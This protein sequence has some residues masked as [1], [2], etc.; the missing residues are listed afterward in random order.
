MSLIVAPPLS[1]KE[2]ARRTVVETIDD[3]CMGMAAQLSYYLCLSL[4]PALLFLIAVSSFFSLDLLTDEVG[5]A[6]G[7]VVSP[8]ILSLIQGQMQRLANGAD[9]GILTLGCIGAL[10]GSSSALVAVVSTVNRAYDLQETRPWWRVRLLALA[11]TVSLA[12]LILIAAAILL[13]GPRLAA[14]LGL[15][16]DSVL[17]GWT[18]ALVRWPMAFALVAFAIGLVYNYAPDADQDWLWVTPGAVVA[19][20]LWLLSSLVFKFYVETF[21]DYEATYGAIGAMLVLL[22]WLYISALGI[23][24]GAELNSEIELAAPYSQAKLTTADGRRVIG[25]RAARLFDQRPPSQATKAPPATGAR[26][27]PDPVP[28][29]LFT[30]LV[31]AL[32]APRRLS[33]DA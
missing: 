31:L 9:S 20:A 7:A 16:P 2:L 1:W 5:G 28:G 14:V 25:K 26:P 15:P 24:V 13:A 27:Q 21:T 17:W 4:F 8:E 11:L 6:L 10:W 30:A 3:D 18:W 23:L 19:T 22:V 32:R 12:F 33:R 29:A